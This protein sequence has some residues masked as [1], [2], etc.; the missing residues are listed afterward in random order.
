L[1]ATLALAVFSNVPPAQF[2]Q[3]R[4]GFLAAGHSSAIHTSFLARCRTYS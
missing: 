1:G 3:G 4:V 2:S